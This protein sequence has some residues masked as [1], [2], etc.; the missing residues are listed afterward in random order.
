MVAAGPF[1][2]KGDLLYDGL[3]ELMSR[4]RQEMPHVLIMMGPF[5]DGMNEDVK[6]GNIS[7][8]NSTGELEFLDFDDVFT[9]VME[10]IQSEFAQLRV[11]TKLV[12]IPSAREIHHINPLPQVPY[13]QSQFPAGFEPILLGN[14]QMFRINDINFGVLNADIIKDLCSNTH[15][16]GVTGKIDES[17][18]SV[19]Q[20]RTFYPIYPGNQSTP[21]EWEQYAKMMFPD[22]V[23]PDVLITPS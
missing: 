23:T 8:R 16:K 17:I 21:I 3:Q 22:G 4:V 11:K 20:Q 19:L 18:K 10:Y 5:V 2:S 15:Q 6:S 1:T 9:K 12:L 14:P 13:A 7:F